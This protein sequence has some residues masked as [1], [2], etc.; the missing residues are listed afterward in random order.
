VA[1]SGLTVSSRTR[2]RI[3]GPEPVGSGMVMRIL[4]SVLAVMIRMPGMSGS[5]ERARSRSC[6]R[7]A[8]ASMAFATSAGRWRLGGA[9]PVNIVPTTGAAAPLGATS[10]TRGCEGTSGPPAGSGAGTGAV[11][12][13][14]AKVDASGRSSRPTQASY[15]SIVR[16]VRRSRVPERGL[17]NSTQ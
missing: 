2:S 12:S 9:S 15:S 14:G 11:V 5:T 16:N 7:E 13:A 17:S 3:G 8:T 10:E 4:L 6:G 1:G